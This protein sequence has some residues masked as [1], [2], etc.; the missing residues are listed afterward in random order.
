MKLFRNEADEEGRG[1]GFLKNLKIGDQAEF[2]GPAGEGSFV[3]KGGANDPLFLFGTGTG[4]APLKA[5]TEKLTQEKSPRPITLFLGVSHF[6]DIFYVEEFEKIK[7]ENPNFDFKIGVSRPK[8]NY[9]GL[10]GRLPD[11][12]ENTEIPQNVEVMVCGSV[13]SVKGIKTKLLELGVAEERIDA[14]GFGDV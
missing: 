1:S 4:I 5:L 12:L 8:E 9:T 14:E 13:I 11:V 6:E 3:P 7:Q 2:F 10:K